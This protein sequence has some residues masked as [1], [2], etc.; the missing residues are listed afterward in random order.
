MKIYETIQ[1][2]GDKLFKGKYGCQAVDRIGTYE[3][4]HLL[5]NYLGARI[6]ET[7][8]GQYIIW[9]DNN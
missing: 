2:A 4:E 7:Y 1:D 3:I 6:I 8:Q 5:K 9:P